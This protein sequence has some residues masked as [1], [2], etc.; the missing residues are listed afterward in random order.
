MNYNG[1]DVIASIRIRAPGKDLKEDQGKCVA[2]EGLLSGKTYAEARNISQADCC[3]QCSADLNCNAASW[4][5]ATEIDVSY[6]H[7]KNETFGKLTVERCRILTLLP[8]RENPNCVLT[9]Q[10]PEASALF[11]NSSVNI[12]AVFNSSE[13]S[14]EGKNCP[15]GE[16]ILLFSGVNFEDELLGR[17]SNDQISVNFSNFSGTF[18][19]LTIGSVY[20][21]TSGNFLPLQKAAYCKAAV[22]SGD[23]TLLNGDCFLFVRD[24]KS[25]SNARA[26]CKGGNLATFPN[27]AD[28][29]RI[30]SAFPRRID[31]NK[32]L[33]IG[34]EHTINAKDNEGWYWKMADGTNQ[35]ATGLPW[36]TDDPYHCYISLT[37]THAHNKK[38]LGPNSIRN[39]LTV[40]YIADGNGRLVD[41]SDCHIWFRDNRKAVNGLCQ[42]K[43]V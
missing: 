28:I 24:V 31:M 10:G 20:I 1:E 6:C 22:Q 3:A 7:F 29:A 23:A 27:P 37:S 34:L 5:P 21:G 32:P 11:F 40:A 43:A 2:M 39:M 16:K 36:W 19:N 33:Y 15:P 41:C 12:S 14:F 26:S 17:N 25:Y 30:A 38:Y 13:G 9:L 18:S 4:A 35:N 42:F 8:N